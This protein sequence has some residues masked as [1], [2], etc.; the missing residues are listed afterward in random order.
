MA[1]RVVDV[2]VPVALD[3]AYSYRVPA[4]LELAPGDIVTVP[5]GPR[6]TTGVVWA[7]N[8]NPN[9][10]LDNR[11]KEIE[12]R[13]D[14]PPLK[15]ELRRFVEWVANY[16][17]SARGMVLRMCL[18]MGE[19]LGAE[20]ERI[21]VRLAGPPPE[22]LTTAR[23]RLLALL[24]D[25]MLR[26]KADAAREAGVSAGVI[27]GLIDEGTLQTVVLPPEPVAEKPDPDFV[28]TEFTPAQSTAA[29]ALKE[30]V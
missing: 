24:A 26:G 8:A 17:L 29:A 27:D 1:R 18:R 20:R 5:L 28:R 23:Q 21:G 6:D 16:T 9:P 22:R 4:A 12:E 10:R 13:L 3:R 25:G 19:H 15:P 7:E 14:F 2:L 11:L 30:T